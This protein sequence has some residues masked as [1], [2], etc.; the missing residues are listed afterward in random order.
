[1]FKKNFAGKW[2]GAIG[3]GGV[4][5]FLAAG[6]GIAGGIMGAPIAIPGALIGLGLGA[7]L[8]NQAGAALDNSTV[9]CPN[10]E[11]FMAV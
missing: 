1:M 11:K 10:C 9:K 3:G 6:L 7:V 5:Y 8:G 2:V 4:G